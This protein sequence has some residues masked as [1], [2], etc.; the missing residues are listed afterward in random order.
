[1]NLIFSKIYNYFYFQIFKYY[2]YELETNNQNKF[3]DKISKIK[4]SIFELD[5][6]EK[7]LL[8]DKKKIKYGQFQKNKII[9]YLENDCSAILIYN[10]IEIMHIRWMA[11]TRKSK[12]YLEPWRINFNYGRDAVWGD[13]YTLPKYRNNKLNSISINNCLE[14]LRNKKIKRVFLSVKR[15]NKININSY[16]NFNTNLYC[17]SIKIKFLGKNFYFNYHIYNS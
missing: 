6:K 8:F 10:E 16:K 13:A 3:E 15:S 5:S 2:I 11:F 1:M 7:L 17:K 14:Y 4:Y 12:K 9:N